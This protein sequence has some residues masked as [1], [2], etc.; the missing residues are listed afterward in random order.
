MVDVTECDLCKAFDHTMDL[1]DKGQKT[2]DLGDKEKDRGNHDKALE[3]YK[4]VW[5]LFKEANYG[6]FETLANKSMALLALDEDGWEEAKRQWTEAWEI[7][8]ASGD[9]SGSKELCLLLCCFA[10]VYEDAET[11]K[12]Y[13]DRFVELGGEA[14]V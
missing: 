7:F 8:E 12:A 9:R 6:S 1:I 3:H 13:N 11:A 14:L 4:A 5:E 10:Q 2:L